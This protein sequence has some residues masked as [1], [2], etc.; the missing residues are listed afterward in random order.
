MLLCTN[1]DPPPQGLCVGQDFMS[2]PPAHRSAVSSRCLLGEAVSPCPASFSSMSPCCMST[3]VPLFVCVFACV[4]SVPLP[5]HGQPE[6]CGQCRARS[7]AGL[8]WCPC[9]A[10]SVAVWVRVGLAACSRRPGRCGFL[11][12][13]LSYQEV[14]SPGLEQWLWILASLHCAVLSSHLVP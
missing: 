3:W 10:F 5:V 7:S 11:L 6:V 1:P 8:S 4:L 9:Q 2:L 14:D 13:G 12:L